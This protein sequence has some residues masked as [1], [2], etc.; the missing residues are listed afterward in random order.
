MKGQRIRCCVFFLMLLLLA[1]PL[2]AQPFNPAHGPLEI[3]VHQLRQPFD[4]TLQEKKF[5]PIN[6]MHLVGIANI[7]AYSGTMVALHKSWY[8]QY[9]QTTFHSFNDLKEWKQMDK[10][11]HAY[12][13]YIASYSTMEMWRWAGLNRRQSAWVGSI[14]GVTFQTMVEVLDGFSEGWGWSWGD[15]GANIFGSGLLLGQELAWQEQRVRYKF[16]FHRKQYRQPDLRSR[17]DDL[18]GKSLPERMLKDYNG[19]TYWLSANLHAFMPKS[20]VPEWF[21][22]AV[23]YG[24]GGLFGG[25]SNLVRDKYNN[26][27]FDR[28]DIKRYRQFYISPDIDFSKIRT[29]NKALKITFG[30]LNA[31]KFP[32]PTLQYNS[33][34]KLEFRFIYF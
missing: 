30:I 19:Q 10:V 20:K 3:P 23:G 13:A 33:T 9:P 14:S 28:T 1:A 31:F 32:A 34:G 17:A 27:I 11:G 22:I 2:I 15:F 6:K 5:S 4:T 24:A 18:F 12:S 29:R 8:S 16:S 25:D 7:A 21:S 26:I